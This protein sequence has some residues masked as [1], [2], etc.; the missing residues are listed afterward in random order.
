MQEAS[1][2]QQAGTQVL[3]PAPQHM[4]AGI[5]HRSGTPASSAPRP[6]AP[7][8]CSFPA[9]CLL[10]QQPNALLPQ[11]PRLPTCFSSR[12]TSPSGSGCMPPSQGTHFLVRSPTMSAMPSGGLA[13]AQ[14]AV[15]CECSAGGSGVW[16]LAQ[17][18]AGRLPD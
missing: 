17:K 10:L 18:R 6:A 12:L 14:G 4:A 11:P 2:Y 13:A 5:L 1:V 3:P 15:R 7:K 16:Q 9:P 8:A